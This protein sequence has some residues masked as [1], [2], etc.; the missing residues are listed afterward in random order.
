MGWSA[1]SLVEGHYISSLGTP[2]MKAAFQQASDEA[3]QLSPDASVD[4]F[5]ADGALHLSD[6]ERMF[7]LLGGVDLRQKYGHPRWCGFFGN[8]PAGPIR[9]RLQRKNWVIIGPLESLS[10]RV[11]D[12]DWGSNL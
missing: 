3:R 2:E 5:L 11:P 6:C 8:S 4:M 12:L 9:A 7:E 10:R 1:D